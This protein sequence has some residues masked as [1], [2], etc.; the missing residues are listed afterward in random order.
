ML[1]NYT[2]IHVHVERISKVN[3]L[4]TTNLLS[5][6]I[7]RKIHVALRHIWKEK[8]EKNNEKHVKQCLKFAFYLVFFKLNLFCLMLKLTR[9]STWSCLRNRSSLCRLAWER[10]S[11]YLFSR[12]CKL[13]DLHEFHN[14]LNTIVHN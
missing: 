7:I 10:A 13:V 1:D 2:I 5:S 12:N 14:F 11:A 3:N 4:P 8:V 6:E 9:N